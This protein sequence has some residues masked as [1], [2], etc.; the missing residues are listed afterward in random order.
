MLNIIIILGFVGSIIFTNLLLKFYLN[1]LF[2]KPKSQKK[3]KKAI[4][5]SKL[6]HKL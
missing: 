5:I 2:P 4:V 3:E 1:F 6:V